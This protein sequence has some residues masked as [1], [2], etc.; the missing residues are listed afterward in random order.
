MLGMGLF[1][2]EEIFTKEHSLDI[3]E[4]TNRD[5]NAKRRKTD[6]K[7]S[8]PSTPDDDPDAMYY[9]GSKTKGGVGYA[10]NVT[11]DVS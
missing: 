5:R 3:S 8:N 9:A 11:E 6:S 1:I 10:G 2:L 7:P 4:S